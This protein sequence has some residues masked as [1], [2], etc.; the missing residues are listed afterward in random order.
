[1]TDISKKSTLKRHLFV[2]VALIALLSI[3]L[4]LYFF[5]YIPQQQASYNKSTLRVLKE[6]A[7]NFS[8]RLWGYDNASAN[9]VKKNNA[10]KY[11]FLSSADFHYDSSTIATKLSQIEGKPHKDSSIRESATLKA[12][13]K[14]TGEGDS[15]KKIIA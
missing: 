2:S 10:L 14:E 3:F 1:M 9:K 11:D 15:A 6:I 13:C 5:I 12:S 4:S 7:E 8:D